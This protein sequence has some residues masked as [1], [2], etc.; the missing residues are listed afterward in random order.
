MGT[1]R[2]GQTDQLTLTKRSLSHNT[3]GQWLV[4]PVLGLTGS[5]SGCWPG[6]LLGRAWGR[7]HFQG[8][9]GPWQRWAPG[10]WRNEVPV[11]SWPVSWGPF[12]W[13]LPFSM[14][15]VVVPSIWCFCMEG[16]L[17]STVLGFQ[18]RLVNKKINKRKSICL[19]FIYLSAPGFNCSTWDL[20]SCCM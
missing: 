3:V 11:S 18:L 5:K 6:C 19:F 7:I 1:Q 17:L 13:L 4:C 9:S 2:V 10:A 15:A 8:L 20:F 16:N 12:L 14:P